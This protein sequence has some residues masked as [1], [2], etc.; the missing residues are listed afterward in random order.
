MEFCFSLTQAPDDVYDAFMCMY[1]TI[2]ILLL[3]KSLGSRQGETEPS[4][5]E[6]TY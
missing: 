6:Q 4:T 2:A 3:F 1:V 5:P